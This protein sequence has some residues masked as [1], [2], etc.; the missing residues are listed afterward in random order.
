MSFDVNGFIG[1]LH[2]LTTTPESI[3]TL[4]NWCIF[5]KPH[6]DIIV[7]TWNTA[8]ITHCTNNNLSQ[9]ITL[10]YLCNEI[11][12]TKI[13]SNVYISVYATILPDT[14]YTIYYHKHISAAHKSKIDRLI[15]IWRERN[16][17]D[18]VWIDSIRNKLQLQPSDHNKN[19]RS[20]N[21]TAVD[22][23]ASAVAPGDV[24]RDELIDLYTT[25]EQ[26]HD[27]VDTITSTA[28]SSLNQSITT[29]HQAKQSTPTLIK[30]RDSLEV[31]IKQSTRLIELLRRSI[32]I[33]HRIVGK[34]NHTLNEVNNKL[35]TA[36]NIIEQ[37]NQSLPSYD[38]TTATQNKKQKLIDGTS[39]SN[40][41][42]DSTDVSRHRS[43]VS[44][45]DQYN[46]LIASLA[47]IKN[48]IEPA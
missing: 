14:L 38:S 25:I 27:Y 22:T 34:S 13:K 21:R 46:Q 20:G 29:Y 3:Q 5:H 12:Q 17:F 47:T 44:P 11:I 16:V 18:N 2:K 31:S 30:Y 42:N 39:L 36:I 41:S 40:Q 24:Y 7:D 15:N 19:N 9:C 28:Q 32:E 1:K 48:A 33:N 10:L 8:I 37:H 6:A 45:D 4:S 43:S 35:I 23:V 26:R